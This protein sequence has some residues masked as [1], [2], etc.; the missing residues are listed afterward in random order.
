MKPW[1]KYGQETP[2]G[3]SSKPW[4]RYGG[5][6]IAEKPKETIGSLLL[7][8]VKSAAKETYRE[9]ISPILSGLS[10]AA[11]GLPKALATKA[12]LKKDIFPEQ[13]TIA[14][15]G[16][17]FIAEA[18]GILGGGALK[19]GQKVAGKV[20]GTAL[21]QKVARGAIE[22][23]V[24]G[25]LQTPETKEGKLLAPVERTKQGLL[26]TILGV[27]IPLAIEGAKKA[28][29][30]TKSGFQT[31]KGLKLPLTSTLE[32]EKIGI[33]A[34]KTEKMRRMTEVKADA[35]FK[36]NKLLDEAKSAGASEEDIVKLK[37]QASQQLEE[38]TRYE[39]T[40]LKDTTQQVF[41]HNKKILSDK[42]QD[43]TEQG[44][45]K[46]QKALPEFGT[47]VGDTYETM[48][49]DVA[50]L[51]EVTRGKLNIQ[52]VNDILRNTLE[53]ANTENLNFGKAY[54]RIN[55][56]WTEKYAVSTS[57][58][59]KTFSLQEVKADISQVFKLVKYGQRGASEEI[60]A[61]ILRKHWGAFTTKNVEG[62]ADMQ[63]FYSDVVDAIKLGDK[64]FK[65]KAGELYAEK[66]IGF[67]RK[68]G[69]AERPSLPQQKLITMLEQ[70]TEKVKGI[71]QISKPITD[72]GAEIR[73]LEDAYQIAQ[74]KMAM[75]GT[76]IGMK[77]G[78]AQFEL[79]QELKQ[80]Q[81]S[82]KVMRSKISERLDNLNIR[83]LH[84]KN[85]LAL[86]FDKQI[87]GL[88]NKIADRKK[89][90]ALARMLGLGA[91]AVAGAYGV[92]RGAANILGFRES[93]GE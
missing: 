82:G 23:G 59:D 18:A 64:I 51:M 88:E 47:S 13:E 60:P 25:L 79:A 36:L 77:L 46:Y 37:L 66:G 57:N 12:G 43:V 68:F 5:T 26:G 4:E 83:S 70:G 62:Y 65:P 20:A 52:E 10:T 15:K 55:D 7:G 30:T 92:A 84:A 87:L 1:E 6:A 33:Q 61:H 56:L 9:V 93:Y 8:N 58:L 22:G 74:R 89:A 67:L 73:G 2:V 72:L 39:L 80:V 41:E 45:L 75:G 42:F 53:E 27:T 24:T 17:R 49:D 44:A 19:I 14:G 54:N 76:D 16:T 63:S 91:G 85:A 71:G 81:E 11:F 69:M 50:D 34:A 78:K 86:K 38:R 28:I 3:E 35:R 90:V 21:R 29:T 48:L 31:L 32:R 40:Q